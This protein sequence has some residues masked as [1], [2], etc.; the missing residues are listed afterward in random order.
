MSSSELLPL[1]TTQRLQIKLD[2]HWNGLMWP[3][4]RRESGRNGFLCTC[5]IRGHGLFPRTSELLQGL[6]QQKNVLTT[7]THSHQWKCYYN[8]ICK[9]TERQ[10][11]KHKWALCNVQYSSHNLD[12][13]WLITLPL[14]EPHM[15]EMHLSCHSCRQMNRP[16]SAK[17][18]TH[19]LLQWS[20]T[21]RTAPESTERVLCCNERL[22]ERP[23]RSSMDAITRHRHLC[24]T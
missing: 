3:A 18:T 8:S 24:A 22:S 17:F 14:K 6:G 9:S 7:T 11:K 16:T 2:S 20:L 19:K 1:Q 4:W 15:S 5:P 12:A 23:L 13:I 21:R 10:W